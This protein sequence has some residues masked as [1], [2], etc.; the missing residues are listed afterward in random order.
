MNIERIKE[1]LGTPYYEAGGCA[2]YNTDCLV[3]MRDLPD[4]VIDL[5][6]TRPPYNIGKEYDNNLPLPDYLDWCTQWIQE[7]Y[8]ITSSGGAFWLNLGY[9][10]MF[11]RAKPFRSLTCC[12]T[13]YPS[14]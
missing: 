10:S 14:S 9:L 5:T 3:A 6:V 1:V 12:G 13:E 2:I 8:R 7:V 11:D 4:E